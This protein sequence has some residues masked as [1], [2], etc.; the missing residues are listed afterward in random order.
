MKTKFLLAETLARLAFWNGVV[1]NGFLSLLAAAALHWGWLERGSVTSGASALFL[2]LFRGRQ[3]DDSWRP[4]LRALDAFEARQPI[5]QT[6]FFQQHDKFQYPLTSLLP[7]YGLRL[8]HWSDAGI[9]SL[10][11]L[12]TWIAFW[13]TI[14]IT[15]RILIVTARLHGLKEQVSR[16]RVYVVALAGAFCGLCFYPLLKNYV[17]GQAQTFISLS[18]AA[19]VYLWLTGRYKSAGA[20]VGLICLIKPQFSLF[21]I[22]FALR[23]KIGSLLSAALVLISGFGAAFLI[24]G[25]K[26]QA[27][28]LGVLRYIA[29]HGESFWPNESL[30]GFLNRL[31]FN[32]SNLHWTADSFAPFSP[33]IYAATTITSVCLIALALLFPFRGSLR[34]GVF[35]F[36]VLALTATIASPVAWE[37]HYG[38]LVPVFAYLA[39]SV[40]ESRDRNLLCAAFVLTSNAW[41]PMNIFAAVPLLNA[42]QSLRLF[43]ALLLLVFL[44]RN[45]APRGEASVS[46]PYPATEALMH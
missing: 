40:A 46:A 4:M 33:Y 36:C 15:V 9:L 23:N 13:L 19:A 22:W 42:L 29:L 35:D 1:L 26:E 44:Y 41:S 5:Y 31:F 45:G 38:I 32:G 7:L 25:W 10:M 30:N 28:Y 37:H 12:L 8:A 24:F 43:G 27:A 18:F 3:G 14:A 34:S 17:L 20:L 6:I 16:P 39:G 21:L 11:N 2:W